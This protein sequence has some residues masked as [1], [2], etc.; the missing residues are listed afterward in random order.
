MMRAQLLVSGTILLGS[1]LACWSGGAVG[2]IDCNERCGDD[3]YSGCYNRCRLEHGAEQKEALRKVDPKLT[4]ALEKR[5][6]QIEEL[7]WFEEDCRDHQCSFVTVYTGT[8][9][10][11]CAVTR[12]NPVKLRCR[13]RH[14]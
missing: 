14:A 2:E 4:A 13:Y 8:G 9:I 5:F 12:R 11:G 3:Y 1:I 7:E 6:P 10:L